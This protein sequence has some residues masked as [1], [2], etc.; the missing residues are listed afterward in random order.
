MAISLGLL[1]GGDGKYVFK[2]YDMSGERVF[3]W[4]LIRGS[5][6]CRERER[7]KCVV[8][9]SDFNEC[10]SMS[11]TGRNAGGGRESW[12]ERAR[13]K[14]ISRQIFTLVDH[15]RGNKKTSSNP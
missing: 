12:K 4:V 7:E 11:S 14:P 13:H 5:G 2:D 6:W 9:C 1:G 3:C 8:E 10:R 15:Y